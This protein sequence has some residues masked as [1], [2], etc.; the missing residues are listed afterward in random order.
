MTLSRRRQ[1]N[2]LA[3]IGTVMFFA[4]VFVVAMLLSAVGSIA[5]GSWRGILNVSLLFAVLGAYYG[6][7]VALDGRSEMTDAD[8]PVLRTALC[9]AFGSL[10]VLLVQAWPPQTFNAIWAVAGAVVGGA[11]GWLGW[12]WAKHIDF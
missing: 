6:T 12:S 4:V 7:I 2:W 10:L 11:L 3:T 5:W 8:R 1:A 9:S